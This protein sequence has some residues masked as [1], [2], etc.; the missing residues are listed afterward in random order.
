MKVNDT[1]IYISLIS[2][3]KKLRTFVEMMLIYCMN[4]IN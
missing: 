1:K 4:I 2:I 3:E